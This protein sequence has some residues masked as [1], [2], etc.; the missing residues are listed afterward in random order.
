MKKFIICINEEI[1]VYDDIPSL[2][3]S[4]KGMDDFVTAVHIAGCLKYQKEMY[5]DKYIL[6]FRDDCLVI[7]N[8]NG[9]VYAVYS[10]DV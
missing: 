8:N 4:L 2:Y 6:T 3:R 9:Y 5:I 7:T 1:R 10:G